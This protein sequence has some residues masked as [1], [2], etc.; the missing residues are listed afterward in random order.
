[1]NTSLTNQQK[2]TPV[3]VIAWMTL[4]SGIVNLIWGLVASAAA[5]HSF[6]G[7]VCIPFTILPTVL[8]IFEVI[9]AAK[10]LSFPPQPVKPS[11]AIAILEIVDVVAGNVFSMVVGILALVFYNDFT[12]REYFARLTGVPAPIAPVVPAEPVSTSA[13]EPAVAPETNFDL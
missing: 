8:G 7:F 10:L 12:V 13:P 2:P 11:T 9:Y 4:A 3:N 6:I 5:L 1:M